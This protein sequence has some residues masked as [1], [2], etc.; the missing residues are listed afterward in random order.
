MP[1]NTNLKVG[2]QFYIGGSRTQGASDDKC[3]KDY[4]PPRLTLPSHWA[5]IDIEFNTPGTVAY[6]TSRGSW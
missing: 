5:P 2:K 3:Q 4:I 1:R 6:M